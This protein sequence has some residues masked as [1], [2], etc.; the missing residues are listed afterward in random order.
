MS[1]QMDRKVGR[2]TVRRLLLNQ[3]EKIPVPKNGI[4]YPMI[5]GLGR[6]MVKAEGFN[7]MVNVQGMIQNVLTDC[8]VEALDN[9]VLYTVTYE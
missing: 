7:S 6:V 9:S 4:E 5:V 2:Y 8:E 1:F 3:G